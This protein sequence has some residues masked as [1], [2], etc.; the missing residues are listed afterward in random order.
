M[1]TIK[2]N[3]KFL[4]LLLALVSLT[5]ACDGEDGMDGINGVDGAQGPA[6]TDGMNG[7]DGTDGA[8]GADGTDGSNGEDGMDGN[9]NVFASPWVEA[10]FPDAYEFSQA[11]FTITDATITQE[12]VNTYTVLA[13]F[14]FSDTFERVYSVPFTEPLLRSF[15]MQMSVSVGEITLT[16]LGNL[17]TVGTIAP[18]DGF[19]RYVLIEPSNT[20]GG[21]RY[22]DPVSIMQQ[23]GVDINDY[24]QVMDYL[25][26]DY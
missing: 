10:D 25:G 14:S 8:D 16:E 7:A 22:A 17:D 24:Y 15:D 2:T 1:K 6:G 20:H 26:L 11:S 3:F 18:I 9:A 13:Y 12:V 4:M 21:S 5:V 19:A 23:A